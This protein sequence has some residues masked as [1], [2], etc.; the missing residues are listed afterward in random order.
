MV[1]RKIIRI[2]EKKCD[3]CGKCIP[4]CAEGAIQLVNGKAV[5][6]SDVYCDGLGACLGDCPL[7]AISMEEREAADFNPEAVRAHLETLAGEKGQAACAGQAPETI[8]RCELQDLSGPA[9]VGTGEPSRLG[10]W[11]IQMQL[12]PARAPFLDGA[13]LLI[14][15]DCVPFAI[16]GFHAAMLKG[17]TLLVACAKLDNPDFIRRKLAQVFIKNNICSIEVAYMEVPCCFGLVHLVHQALKD[18]GKSIPLSLSKVGIRGEVLEQV[19]VDSEKG[20]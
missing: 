2:D 16:A 3:G 8:T 18:S 4:A 7:G 9:G 13:D 11:P 19:L 10:N 12:V 5:L 15:A 14:A 20:P 17:K 6:V 1:A